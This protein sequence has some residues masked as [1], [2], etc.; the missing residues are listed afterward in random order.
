MAV[1]TGHEVKIS[2]SVLDFYGLKTWYPLEKNG[3][4][5]IGSTFQ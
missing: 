4:S 3:E 2:V 5:D 1:G